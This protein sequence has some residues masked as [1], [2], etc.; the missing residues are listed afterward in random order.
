MGRPT[1]RLS[2]KDP[3]LCPL[4][5]D[6]PEQAPNGLWRGAHSLGVVGEWQRG[7]GPDLRVEEVAAPPEA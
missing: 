6:G 1:P 7:A 2:H 4:L 5:L 3:A